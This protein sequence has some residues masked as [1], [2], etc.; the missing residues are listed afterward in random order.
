MFW[1][2]AC[3]MVTWLGTAAG[4]VM[5]GGSRIAPLKSARQQGAA[6]VWPRTAQGGAEGGEFRPPH[7]SG[8]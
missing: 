8:R 4:R 1:H 3:G 5:A 2:R 7:L 6:P